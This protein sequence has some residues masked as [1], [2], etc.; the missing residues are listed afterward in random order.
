[1]FSF[2]LAIVSALIFLAT[3][4]TDIDA[5]CSSGSGLFGRAKARR[6]ARQ[7]SRQSAR[8]G[9]EVRSTVSYQSV[10]IQQ[11]APVS[12]PATQQTTTRITSTSGCPGGVCP[13]R[14]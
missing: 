6:A 11:T 10:P 14:R 12:A 1:M 13:I 2:R 3:A 4:P 9:Y 7:E 5:G 8:Y